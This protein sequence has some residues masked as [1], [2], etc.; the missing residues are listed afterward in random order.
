MYGCVDKGQTNALMMCF[1][2]SFSSVGV[3]QLRAAQQSE[4]IEQIMTAYWQKNKN[5]DKQ[6]AAIFMDGVKPTCVSL[7]LSPLVLLF[8]SLVHHLPALVPAGLSTLSIRYSHSKKHNTPMRT[9]C[10]GHRESLVWN[11]KKR[12]KLKKDKM[13][14]TAF[15]FHQIVYIKCDINDVIQAC[16]DPTQ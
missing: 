2:I 7:Q 12:F 8:C 13:L 5:E 15:C 6:I 4:T 10:K 14:C 16:L 9:G 11:N 3:N 1:H